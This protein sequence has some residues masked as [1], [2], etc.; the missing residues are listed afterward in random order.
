MN[1][2]VYQAKEKIDITVDLNQTRKLITVE[3]ERTSNL[4]FLY[5]EEYNLRVVGKT[6]EQA[7]QH[8]KNYFLIKELKSKKYE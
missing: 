4:V 7:I 5:S 8:L 3:V 6:L 1:F 2:R